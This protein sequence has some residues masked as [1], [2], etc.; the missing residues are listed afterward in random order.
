MGKLIVY[1]REG[2][3][4]SMNTKSKLQELKHKNNKNFEIIINIVPN[5]EDEKN[6]IK[7]RLRSI[8][9]NHNTF[10]IVIYETSDKKQFFI[11]GDSNLMNIFD[12]VNNLSTSN[13]TT[14]INSIKN[15]NLQEGERR[16]LCQIAIL[17]KKLNITDLEKII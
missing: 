1:C 17:Q 7:N 9:G 12:C 2:C 11:G 16:L 10:P 14:T 3:H 13:V 6:K 4:Y 5:D 8:I 15:L